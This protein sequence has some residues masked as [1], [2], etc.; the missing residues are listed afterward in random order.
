MSF[1]YNASCFLTP[2]GLLQNPVSY[3]VGGKI[4]ISKALWIKLLSHRFL[5]GR[6]SFTNILNLP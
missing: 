3:C 6:N 5:W 2:S 4:L 1:L